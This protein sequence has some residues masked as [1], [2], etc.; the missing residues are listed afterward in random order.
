MHIKKNDILSNSK[1]KIIDIDINLGY[2]E[3]VLT[4]KI[5][6]FDNNIYKLINDLECKKIA[7]TATITGSYL[8]CKK[9][10]EFRYNQLK[11]HNISFIKSVANL[12]LINNFNEIKEYVAARGGFDNRGQVFWETTRAIQFTFTQGVFSKT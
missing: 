5:Y 10:E 1:G 4:S 11:N 3:I 7:L 8:N 12:V 9:I 2:L 6:V